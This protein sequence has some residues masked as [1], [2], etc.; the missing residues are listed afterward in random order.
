VKGGEDM[1]K[2]KNFLIIGAVAVGILI[3][4][5][6][7]FLFLNQSTDDNLENQTTATDEEIF[8]N[9][10]AQEATIEEEAMTTGSGRYIEFTQGTLEEYSNT[11]RVLFFYAN[12]CPT[13][14]PIDTE[15][16]E[17]ESQIPEGMSIVRVN[18]NDPDTD[19]SEKDLARTYNVVNQ[20][21]F[22]QIDENGE[23]ITKWNGGG[24][25]EIIENTK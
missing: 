24:L 25:E 17:N 16:N 3:L 6:A 10:T 4:A 8:E 20:H 2:N 21:T 23:E 5:G 18:F 22:V 1:E 19:D 13:C 9:N 15:L 11:N 7:G 14:R 12:W